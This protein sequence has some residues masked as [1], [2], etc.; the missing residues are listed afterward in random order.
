MRTISLDE[1][2]CG[3]D[4]PGACARRGIPLAVVNARLSPG[5]FRGYSALGGIAR[6]MFASAALI[7]AQSSLDAQRLRNLGVDDRLLSVT[8]NLKFDA[9][10]PASIRSEGALLREQWGRERPVFIAASTHRGEESQILRAFHVGFLML[11]AFPMVASAR[12]LGLS[13]KVVA[14][15]LAIVG[16]GV[17][18]YQYVE[19]QPLILRAGD[20]TSL[21]IVFGEID[22]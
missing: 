5:S 4:I 9:A 19:Y 2:F 3:A 8:G 15:L 12:R 21:D 20:P 11:L 17:A 18:L 1:H 22:R 7:C 16:A 13:G 10:V 14:W 6:E